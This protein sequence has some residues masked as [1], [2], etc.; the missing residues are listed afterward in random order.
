MPR[1]EEGGFAFRLPMER[2]PARADGKD[3]LDWTDCSCY[4]KGW[5]TP[6]ADANTTP[7]AEG[8]EEKRGLLS[9][10]NVLLFLVAVVIG[11]CLLAYWLIP[12]ADETAIRLGLQA[13]DVTVATFTPPAPVHAGD[14]LSSDLV[15]L[16]LDGHSIAVTD[17]A[18][19]S[20]WRV[21]FKLYGLVKASDAPNLETKLPT[22]SKRLRERI[23]MVIRESE[24]TDLTEPGL[25]LI[26]RKILAKVNE[27]LGK[28]LLK[29]IAVNDFFFFEH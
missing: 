29:G 11:E 19:G 17:V 16:D 7:E 14:A 22:I 24:P 25:G 27:A 9:R 20:I 15:E 1:S 12:S 23:D 2:W 26:K 13:N 18:S 21:D 3:G 5:K 10:F 4:A 8:G 28:P 6:M